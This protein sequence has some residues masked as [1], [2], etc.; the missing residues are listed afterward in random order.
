MD[1]A[2]IETTLKQAIGRKRSSEDIVTP[3]LVERLA[4][5]LESDA[6]IPRAGDELPPGWHTIFCIKAPAR[7]QLGVD[8]LAAG[9][10]LIPAV[11]MQ[12]RMFGGARLTFH[13]PLVVGQKIR[14]ESEMVGAR[15]RVAPSGHIAIVTVRHSYIGPSGLAVTEEQ[16]TLHLQPHPEEATCKEGRSAEGAGEHRAETLPAATWQRSVSADPVMLFRFSALC[17]NSHRIHY[18]L[19]YSTREENLPALMVQG[20]LIA[21]QLLETVRAAA[22]SRRVESFEY[23][24]GRPLF[25]GRG[26]V[27]K[28]TLDRDGRTARA[29][30]EDG[31][32]RLVQ[33]ATLGLA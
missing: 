7:T 17:F 15:T 13:A 9:D 8:G 27:L 20:K 6:G 5:T 3:S 11:P 1:L 21:L 22:P 28:V 23:R 2:G 26:C 31:Q 10:E 33:S 14:C 32:G 25:S 29:W 4:V 24:S 30:A 16:D 12:R 18:D 19:P